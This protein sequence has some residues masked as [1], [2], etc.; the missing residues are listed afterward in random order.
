M[1]LY[2]EGEDITDLGFTEIDEK[3]EQQA[4]PPC[5]CGADRL[6]RD[7]TCVVCGW[8]PDRDALLLEKQQRE[9]DQVFEAIEAMVGEYND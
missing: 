8:E 6:E 2:H 5:P 7:D 4:V 1:R 3:A 9:E